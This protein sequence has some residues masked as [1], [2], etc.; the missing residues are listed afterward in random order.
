VKRLWLTAVGLLVFGTLG[1]CARTAGPCWLHPGPEKCQQTR[2]LRYDPYPENE[3]GPEMVGVRPRD[4]QKPP[5]ETSRPRWQLGN[6][7][8]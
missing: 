5:P 1:G 4:Y 6:W 7:G 3:P 8:Q 2:A